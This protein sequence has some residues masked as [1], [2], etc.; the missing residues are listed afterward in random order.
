MRAAGRDGRWDADTAVE[1]M[2]GGHYRALVR[3]SVLLV[4]DVESAEE[5]VARRDGSDAFRSTKR[6]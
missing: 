5:V 2:Y 4:G 6:R 1:Q 3:L